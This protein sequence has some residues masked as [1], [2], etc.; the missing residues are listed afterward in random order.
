ML[1]RAGKLKLFIITVALLSLMAVGVV[2]YQ[3]R[4]KQGRV[5]VPLPDSATKALMTLAR[6][7]QTA[8][9]EGRLQWEL[10]AESAQLEVDSGRMVLQSPQVD[11]FLEDGSR[12]HLTAEKGI[13][14][15]RNN[16]IQASGNVRIRNDRY[17]LITDVLN[18][19]HKRR[20]LK[21][22]DAVK[23]VG[24]AFDLRADSMTYNL[25][26]NRAQFDGQVEGTIHEN[27]AL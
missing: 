8:T 1:S 21:T 20:I 27:L 5:V 24:K 16:N 26:T 13:L 18:Y 23:I 6:I 14:N 2:F 9:K 15:T 4:Q 7:H 12:V 22:N 17:T 25:T 3:Y 11:F 19:K 10:D